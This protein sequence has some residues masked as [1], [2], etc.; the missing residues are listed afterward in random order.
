MANAL[1]IPDNW[2]CFSP[3]GQNPN[4]ANC[5]WKATRLMARML[6]ERQHLMV[7]DRATGEREDE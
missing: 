4:G 2:N 5:L 6:H 1:V 3:T 7:C